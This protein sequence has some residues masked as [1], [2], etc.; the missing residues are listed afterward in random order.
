MMRSR[1]W[2]VVVGVAFAMGVT[3]AQEKKAEK[4][5]AGPFELPL[6]A[7]VK[8]KCKT[9]DDQN[10]KLETVYKDAVAKEEQT[11][12][13]AKDNQTERKDLE[14]FLLMGKNDTINRIKEVLDKEQAKAFDGLISA[15]DGAAEKKKKK[16][17]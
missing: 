4:A 11:R 17:T 16:K 12:K 9:N 13:T 6:L 5:A 1:I 3:A 8:E 14:K 7:S 2:M 15:A 10:G